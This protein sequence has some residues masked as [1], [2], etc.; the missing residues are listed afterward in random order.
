MKLQFA[1]IKT[2]CNPAKVYLFFSLLLLLAMLKQN[3]NDSENVFCFGNYECYVENKWILILSKVIYI[4]FWTFVLNVLCRGGYKNLSWFL[5]LFP[6]ILFFILII[7]FL[8]LNGAQMTLQ[9][10]MTQQTYNDRRKNI[11]NKY[12]RSLDDIEAQRSR[13]RISQNEYYSKRDKIVFDRTKEL[14]DLRTQRD[15][16]VAAN[17][18]TTTV[19]T[20]QSFMRNQNE[21]DDDFGLRI[22]R[23]ISGEGFKNSGGHKKAVEAIKG[24]SVL[25][26]NSPQVKDLC[27]TAMN[28]SYLK[29]NAIKYGCPA[30]LK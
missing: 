3:I 26:A 30:L 20:P 13:G 14:N 28:I 10:G 27:N 23:T 19:I 9:E 21:S 29:Q 6:V 5:I 22:W 25:L 24:K 12:K 15:R 1:D 2:L 11:I 16:E 4:G 8:W 7:G 17:Q 18:K